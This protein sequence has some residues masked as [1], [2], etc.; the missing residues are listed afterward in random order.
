MVAVNKFECVSFVLCFT[1]LI[2]DVEVKF[3]CEFPV[4]QVSFPSENNLVEKKSISS[5]WRT[6]LSPF[7]R[8]CTGLK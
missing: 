1:V 5:I 3:A 8:F 6:E 7:L 4:C 2:K